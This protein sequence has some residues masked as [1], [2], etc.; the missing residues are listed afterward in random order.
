MESKVEIS[1]VMSVY[2]SEKWLKDCISSILSQTFTNFEFI[3][4]NDGSNDRSEFIIQSFA[5]QD[6]RIK[7]YN[8]QNL[9]LTKSLN[10]AISLS[11]G[12]YIARIDADDISLPDRLKKQ[13]EILESNNEIGLSYTSYFEIDKV[14]EKIKK[15]I[16]ISKFE[17][18][19][20]NLSKGVNNIAHS[21]VMFR[22]SIFE[23]LNGYR[24]KFKKSQDIDLW[25]RMMKVTSFSSTGDQAYVHIRKHNLSITFNEFDVYL[26]ISVLSYLAREN[27][28][29][30]PLNSSSK[31]Y[32]IFFKWI[33][34]YLISKKEN[35]KSRKMDQIRFLLHSKCLRPI[36]IVGVFISVLISKYSY[37]IIFEKFFGYNFY[38]QLYKEWKFKFNY[39]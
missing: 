16:A 11:S 33:E 4:I 13:Y 35:L 10:K 17:K 29:Y 3:I 31:D 24:E 20:Y 30:D 25:L 5:Y 12:K 32:N 19:K 18:I 39:T 26:Y 38:G 23:M 1:V 28:D 9:G 34:E 36:E 7:L 2:N 27:L 37:I 15:V 14:G 8:Q 21:S 22:K 6:K